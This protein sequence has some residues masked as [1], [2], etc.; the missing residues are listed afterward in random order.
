MAIVSSCCKMLDLVHF[1]ERDPFLIITISFILT[2]LKVSYKL[3]EK[4]IIVKS[5][6]SNN[7]GYICATKESVNFKTFYI[8]LFSET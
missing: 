8:E 2:L 6:W 1:N 3:D 7:L 4:R 5:A